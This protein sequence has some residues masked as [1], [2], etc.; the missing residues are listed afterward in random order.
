[1]GEEIKSV[2]LLSTGFKES[3]S[4]SVLPFWLQDVPRGNHW[5]NNQDRNGRPYYWREYLP[6]MQKSKGYLCMK[7]I[8][9]HHTYLQYSIKHDNWK[10]DSLSRARLFFKYLIIRESLKLYLLWSHQSN[11]NFLEYSTSLLWSLPH[12]S[13]SPS[14]SI[15][16]KLEGF[17]SRQL[18][19]LVMHQLQVGIHW[20]IQWVML[21]L[22]LALQM[23]L[24]QSLLTAYTSFTLKDLS[25]L[26]VN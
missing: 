16:W 2:C 24:Q 6:W 10:I 25:S 19:P 20:S 4:Q 8:Y 14:T 26:V 11:F 5:G 13:P 9:H 21:K 12:H 17:L 7:S 18:N 23:F 22:F 15:S 1:M 3:N